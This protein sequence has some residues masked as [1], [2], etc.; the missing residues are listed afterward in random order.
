MPALTSAPDESSTAGRT[1]WPTSRRITAPA[2]ATGSSTASSRSCSTRCTWGRRPSR[3]ASVGCSV[4][5]YDYLA[6]DFVEAPHGR[7]P[8]V[9]TGVRRV[10]P[11]AFVFTY[12]GDGDLA[13][14]GTAEIVHAAARG[15]RISV[16]FVNNGIYGMTGGQMA[17]TTLLGQRTTSSPGG[18][19]ASTAGYPIP[20]T[21]MLALLPGVS[22][23]ARGSIADPQWIG[24]TKAMMRRAFEDPAE[25]RWAV[26]RGGPLDL[27]GRLGDDP[28]RVD[29][30]PG[31]GRRPDI[32]ARC[33]RRPHEG[34][35]RTPERADMQHATI[36]GGFGGQGLLFAGH[37]LA[38]AA[39][40][41]G[42][43]VSWMPSYGPEMR[44][45]T[46]SCTVIIADRPIGS[47]IVDSADSVI[48]LNPP[49]LAKFEPLLVPGGL[50]IVNATLIE[51][52][53]RRTDIEVAA[54]PCTA[55]ARAGGDDRF[56]SVVALG[57]L[58]ARRPIVGRESL[59][60][61]LVE[62]LG[63]QRPQMIDANLAA[64][65][66]GYEAAAGLEI[67]TSVSQIA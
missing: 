2:A 13:A 52:E 20:I 36:F 43:T 3:V 31:P 59:R 19:E 45:G 38:Q 33:P 63:D 29:G 30:A 7:A 18:R 54:I 47:P 42:R 50:L 22:Y 27:P 35:G 17:P 40:I 62:V 58:I 32:S 44:G 10:R 57:G 51:A 9:A 8:A 37:V 28:D 1:C 53:P 5:A 65:S 23:A 41:E 66:S 14:I 61:A 25:R 48:A 6:V 55:L 34:P 64:F 11:D 56:V 12:Q 49:S 46:A 15:E 4:F 21:E 60:Q 39:V 16:I 24:R 67:T 26:D